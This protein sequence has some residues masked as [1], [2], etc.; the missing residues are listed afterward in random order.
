MFLVGNSVVISVLFHFSFFEDNVAV[1]ILFI[2]SFILH[3]TARPKNIKL[4]EKTICDM[5]SDREHI[6]KNTR[7]T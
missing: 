6:H 2:H 1:D 5:Q 7:N 3:Q 4:E